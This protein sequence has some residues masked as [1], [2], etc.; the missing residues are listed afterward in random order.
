[1]SSYLS[2]LG[3]ST[4]DNVV[5]NNVN[6]QNV[7]T[8]SL[9]DTSLTSGL[10]SSNASGTLQNALVG[11]GLNYNTSNNTL[12]NTGVT[13]I[14]A[15]PTGP[16]SI[17]SSTGAI[18]INLPQDLQTTSSPNF[19]NLGILNDCI[20]GST[21]GTNSLLASSAGYVV[22]A[23]SNPPLNYDDTTSRLSISLVGSTGINYNVIGN[24][25]YISAISITGPTGPTGPQGIQG[26]QGPTGPSGPTGPTGA[27]GTIGY[28]ANYYSTTT[29]SIGTTAQQITFPN[30][31]VQ[32][33]ISLDANSNIIFNNPGTYKISTLLQV[34]GSNN[35]KFNHWYRYNGVDVA[36]SSFEDHFS[37]GA[38]QVL[39]SSSG[40]ITVNA[41]DYL[42]IWG[43]NTAGTINI[44]YTPGSVSPAFPASTS[45]NVSVSQETYTQIG[46][47]GATGPT[48]PDSAITTNFNLFH[49]VGAGASRVS[50]TG[51]VALGYNSLNALTTADRCTA[52]GFN[53]LKN[54]N[55]N[56]CTAVGRSSLESCTSG[57]QNT[58]VGSFAGT[59]VTTGN[60]NTLMGMSAGGLLTT[61]ST[62]LCLGLNSGYSITTSNDNISLGAY[63]MARNLNQMTGVNGRNV[64][65][66][67]YASHNLAGTP[68]NNISVGYQS[69]YN[70][71]S[72]SDNICIGTNAGN[73]ITTGGGNVALGGS[74][75]STGGT[76]TA[77][78]GFNIG[79]G[80][81]SNLYVSNSAT[82]NIGIGAYSN[83][84]T[85]TGVSN[86]SIGQ[87]T[88]ASSATGSNQIV[89]STNGTSGTPISG[90]G[91]N[92]CFIDARSGLYSY[93]PYSINLW[94]NNAATVSQVEQWVLNNTANSGI[95]NIGTTPTITSGNITGLPLG[96]YS[97]NI[98]GSLYGS[99]QTYYPTL[100]YKA[101]G[102]SFVRVA[103]A[104]PSF[105][106]AWTCPIAI[107]A[108]IRISNTADAIRLWYDTSNP[109]PYNN[110]GTVPAIYYGNYLPR[111]MTITFISL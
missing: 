40:L 74:S 53:S 4:I 95:A 37:S 35:A 10:V 54:A 14:V 97:F 52:V 43:V 24:T 51:C 65:L 41:G 93:I 25:G 31:F 62:N 96:V 18:T 70:A 20:I 78:Q 26:I 107:N 39:S 79:I 55:A 111:Y 13:S 22:N 105:G 12:S 84:N 7:T 86:I 82:N 99:N 66:G 75:L 69:L 60:Y 17:S 48:G 72:C 5:G 87:Y 77:G 64:A 67:H 92:T 23:I 33:G 57:F 100:Q 6:V 76:L 108:N 3:I 21:S 49:G 2:I 80:V 88:Q 27:G 85:S 101:N 36:N 1:M 56:N 30:N 91:D 98:T 45:V 15:G 47:T 34:N 81:A 102:G 83:F 58:A 59:F 9:T 103:L 106:G 89:I 109:G 29:Q 28:Y 46:P 63:T 42:G 68:E 73:S 44:T 71:T 11:T 110:V 61:G 16:I 19:T 94:N 32:N 8:Q 38:G 50:S 104:M 90:K